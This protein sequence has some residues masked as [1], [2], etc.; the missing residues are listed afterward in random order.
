MSFFNLITNKENQRTV[1]LLS[2]WA[3]LLIGAFMLRDIL[4]PFVFAAILAYILNPTISRLCDFKFGKYKIPKGV[5]VLAV[6]ILIGL[7]LYIFATLF[8]PEIYREL[9]RLGKVASDG[10]QQFN[11]TKIQ[12][13]AITIDA[14]FHKYNLPIHII[15]PYEHGN[16]NSIVQADRSISINL[17]QIIH[18]GINEIGEYIHAQSIDIVESLQHIIRRMINF[19]F[20]FFLVLMLAGFMLVDISRIKRFAFALSLG[21]LIVSMPPSPVVKC[22]MA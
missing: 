5:A 2:L 13:L 8:L 6:Y 19:I 17:A 18:N 15:A 20:K 9:L 1:L 11:Q 21:S 12:E 10:V 3:L 14:F 4:L 22:L 7:L 16:G